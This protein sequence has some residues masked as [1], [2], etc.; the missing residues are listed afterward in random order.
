MRAGGKLFRVAE[1]LA[2]VLAL[3]VAPG[4]E[5]ALASPDDETPGYTAPVVEGDARIVAAADV[6]V[7]DEE[8]IDQDGHPVKIRELFAER[9]VAVNFVFTTCTTIC[10]PMSTIFGRLQTVLGPAIERKVSRRAG[11]AGARRAAAREGGA[12]PADA[13]R[14]RVGPALAA[15]SRHHA[16]GPARG[17]DPAVGSP[18]RRR[19]YL[20]LRANLHQLDLHPRMRGAQRPVRELGEPR[21]QQDRLVP[22]V[23]H[24]LCEQ[25][26][27]HHSV[28]DLLP[29]RPILGAERPPLL[30]P[31][32]LDLGPVRQPDQA[33]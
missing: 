25:R 33:P 3:G 2:A 13:D 31:C 28:F 23:L 5:R 6:M 8:L 14:E 32:A 10:S 20:Q 12:P 22:G 26:A 1:V 19:R 21:G 7:P 17:V 9:V 15:R 30:S 29:P 18:L 27:P 16:A 4:C 24:E 11:A